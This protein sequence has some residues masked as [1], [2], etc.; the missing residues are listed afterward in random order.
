MTWTFRGRGGRRL[1]DLDAPVLPERRAGS[2]A[3]AGEE[4]ASRRDVPDDPRAAGLA[5]VVAA[6]LDAEQRRLGPAEV[7][8]LLRLLHQVAVLDDLPEE[9]VRGQEREVAAEV[10][11]ALDRRRTR[12]S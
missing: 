3:G 7:A 11:I 1:V 8:P 4:P 6:V 5:A 10:A 9:V 12:G 2:E